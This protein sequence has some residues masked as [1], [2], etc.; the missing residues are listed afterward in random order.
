[1]C[2][3]VLTKWVKVKD[4]KRIHLSEASA[5]RCV[6]NNCKIIARLCHTKQ[7]NVTGEDNAT[8]SHAFNANKTRLTLQTSFHSS[9]LFPSSRQA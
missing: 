2:F 5:K 8:S 1:M 3:C 9:V 4:I 7:N 6:Q